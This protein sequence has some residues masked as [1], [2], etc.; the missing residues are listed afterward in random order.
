M[1]LTDSSI[2]VLRR[3]IHGRIH[4]DPYHWLSR[5]EDSSI[6]SFLHEENQRLFESTA[7]LDALQRA[8]ED[9]FRA[10]TPEKE[11]DLPIRYGDWWYYGY[12]V[13]GQQHP[14]VRR[15]KAVDADE[16][17]PNPTLLPEKLQQTVLDFNALAPSGG[18]LGMGG[19]D[20][21]E[22]GD[23]V[24][25]AIDLVGSENY[26]LH[27]QELPSGE[28]RQDELVDIGPGAFLAHDGSRVF[29][30]KRDENWRCDSIWEHRIGEEQSSDRLLYRESDERFHLSFHPSRSGRYLVIHAESRTTTEELLFDLRAKAPGAAPVWSRRDGIKYTAEHIMVG[31]VDHLL[32]LHNTDDQDDHFVLTDV[33]LKRPA[34]ATGWHRVL[35]PPKGVQLLGIEA[36]AQMIV[37]SFKADMRDRIAIVRLGPGEK[38]PPPETQ[39]LALTRW[40]NAA[41][42]GELHEV[43]VNDPLIE[44]RSLSKQRWEQRT[45][46]LQTRSFARPPSFVEYDPASRTFVTLR[47]Q[48]VPSHESFNQYEQERIWATALDG[49]QVPIS[50][51][52]N[53][54][55]VGKD[56][57]PLVLYAYGAYGV[58]IHAGFEATRLSLLDRGVICAIAHVRGGGEMGPEWHAGG[59]LLTKRNTFTDLIAC[60][61]ELIARGR[62]SP[63]RIVIEGGS[64]GGLTVGAAA[65][66]A[67]ELFAGVIAEVP[68]VDPLN[69]LLDASSPL[70][71]TEWEEWGN[72]LESVEAFEYIRSYSPYE[73]IPSGPDFPR[74]LALTSMFDARVAYYEA[75]KWIA[76]LRDNGAD[77]Y[78]AVERHGGHTRVTGREAAHAS[79][80]FVYAWLIDTL[81]AD[82]AP[83]SPSSRGR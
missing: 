55:A 23:R 46:R 6:V 60:A 8:I 41:G 1:R 31:D 19:F 25:Y 79:G 72:P 67:P 16:L 74:V 50:V 71:V 35:T 66:L 70:T 28:T 80:A 69:T 56:P 37:L 11:T 3:S 59:R 22:N 49:T 61:R 63:K 27:V 43:D 5:A 2:S 73:N 10:G 65:N 13:G 34:D 53:R 78:L 20:F 83:G 14:C 45:L 7:H 52:W 42:Y 44:A 58:S 62:T 38:T 12:I 32:V 21:S 51:V 77:A 26:T 81:R 76:R 57:A 64:A 33:E 54:D 36:F 17:P 30:S 39:N 47:S 24:I 68:F 75:A 29:Y 18:Y 9:E 40:A 82:H 4:E 48:S 15:V